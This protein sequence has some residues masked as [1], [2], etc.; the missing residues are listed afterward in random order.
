MKKQIRK[1]MSRLALAFLVCISVATLNSSAAAATTPATMTSGLE[2]RTK[3]EIL[4]M[5]NIM[6]LAQSVPIS[7]DVA[8]DTTNLT[9][10]GWLSDAVLQNALD[11]VNFVRYIAGLDYNV[12]LSDE[13][14]QYAQDGA[15]V[16]SANNV[17]THY[18]DQPDGMDWYLWRSGYKGTSS[19]NIASGYSNLATSITAGW[20]ADSTGE[21]NLT[22]VGHRNW[23]LTPDL[24]ATG[25][26]YVGRY[27]AMYVVDYSNDD[28]AYGFSWPSPLMPVEYFKSSYPWSFAYGTSKYSSGSYIVTLT[29]ETT[30]QV[31]K[32][33]TAKGYQANDSYAV[34]NKTSYGD[35]KACIVFRPSGATY[36]NGDVYNV[37]ITDLQL[38]GE[39]ITVVDYTV[40]FFSLSDSYTPVSSVS[41]NGK[42]VDMTA[43]VSAAS[44]W[45]KTELTT[46]LS[47]GYPVALYNDDFTQQ[48]TRGEFAHM[49]GMF[50]AMD[51]GIDVSDVENVF[52]DLGSASSN[53]ERNK[54][55]L[56]L[57]ELGIING[58]S[59]TTF[60]PDALVT[61]EQVAKMLLAYEKLFGTPSITQDITG[62]TDYSQ[63]S[64]W[65]LDGVSYMNQLGVLNGN[66]ATTLNPQGDVT[67]EEAALMCYRLFTI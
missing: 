67:I 64:S 45:A 6:N 13:Y 27:S 43:Q 28:S 60:E 11:T 42:T 20:M 36:S 65:A 52:T 5:Y 58:T 10:S 15:L 29:N 62:Y 4:T 48:M 63:I 51:D 44:S 55:I 33:Y 57:Y 8:P 12:V 37:L 22:D 32:M 46:A 9:H 66:T 49:L 19:S 35:Q 1:Y 61:R 54:C 24:G 25:F 53:A 21:D 56:Y 39:Q 7:Y 50:C 31:W 34:I 14:T 40:E 3:D 18:P 41:Y 2:L 26:G 38:S 59:A 16:N 17:L 47:E 23:I 30:G